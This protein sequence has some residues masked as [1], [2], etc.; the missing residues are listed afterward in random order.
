MNT[1]IAKS[2]ALVTLIV[3][4]TASPAWA[5]CWAAAGYGGSSGPSGQYVGSRDAGTISTAP[6]TYTTSFVGVSGSQCFIVD[7]NAPG[8]TLLTYFFQVNGT[9]YMTQISVTFTPPANA[10]AEPKYAILGVFYAPPCGNSG[11]MVQYGTSYTDSTDTSIS[12]SFTSSITATASYSSSITQEFSFEASLSGNWS[13]TTTTGT[14]VKTST[15]TDEN[16]SVPGCTSAPDGV[17]HDY[18]R[19]SV[20]LNPITPYYYDSTTAAVYLA[21]LAV[22]TRDPASETDAP[23]VVSLT[24]SQLKQLQAGNTSGIAPGTLTSLSRSWDT[25]WNGPGTAG[26]QSADYGDILSADPFAS[27]PTLDPDTMPR[28]TP[29]TGVTFPYAP[30]NPP[31]HT[32]YQVSTSSTTTASSGVEDKHSVTAETGGSYYGVGLKVNYQWTWDYKWNT[33]SSTGST[34]NAMVT[35]YTPSTTDSPPYAGPVTLLP[36]LDNV[37]GTYVL[38]PE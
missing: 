22:D 1:A 6:T 35:V 15:T 29:V 8:S 3:S 19:I 38:F 26:L 23:D 4:L 31:T 16:Y 13:S 36:Y 17:N 11:N 28:F 33:S 14:D 27:N 34:Q 5:N 10:Y 37:Y 30:Q 9:N 32:T 24:V 20:W 25:T 21:K 12:D 7:P 18:D 2:L